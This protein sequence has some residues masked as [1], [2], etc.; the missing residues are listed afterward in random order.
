VQ[1]SRRPHSSLRAGPED[2]RHPLLLQLPPFGFRE[3]QTEVCF[4]IVAVFFLNRFPWEC[5]VREPDLPAPQNDGGSSALPGRFASA[6]NRSFEAFQDE[7]AP[8]LR[9]DSQPLAS[10]WRGLSSPQSLLHISTFTLHLGEK[11]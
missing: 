6:L 1:P 7:K 4:Q 3:G 10:L 2:A 11:N 9:G 8:A 5:S